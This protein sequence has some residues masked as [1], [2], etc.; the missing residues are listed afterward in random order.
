RGGDPGLRAELAAAR[1][2][3]A[4][5]TGFTGSP[6]EAAAQFPQAVAMWEGLVAAQPGNPAY[7]EELAETLNDQGVV[8]LRLEGR[9]AE[10]LRSFDRARDLIEPLIAA[11]PRSVRRREELG[12]ILQNI[13]QIQYEQ[14]Q[15]RAAI[16]SLQRKLALGA[17]LASEDPHALGPRISL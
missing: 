12:N 17:Q 5:I 1:S 15:P 16:E 10:A 8:L 7:R 2:R 3:V 14:G 11:D 4:Q 13:A 6:A 9:R